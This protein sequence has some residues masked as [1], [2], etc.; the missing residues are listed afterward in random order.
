[1]RR[2]VFAVALVFTVLLAYLTVLDFSRHGVTAIG[3]L[4]VLIV[5]LFGIGFVGALRHPPRR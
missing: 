1:M 2:I 5:V 4:G 3:V